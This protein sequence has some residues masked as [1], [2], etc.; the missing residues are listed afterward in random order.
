MDNT[1]PVMGTV[2][3]SPDTAKVGETTCT[4][5]ATDVD[6]GT[7]TMSYAWSTGD[8][9]ASLVITSAEDPGDT[10]TCT[11]TATDA[12]GEPTPGWFPPSSPTPTPSWVW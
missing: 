11:A 8:T 1:D 5:T 7:P 2:S 6:G 4:A 9:G 10:L 3:V 12:D